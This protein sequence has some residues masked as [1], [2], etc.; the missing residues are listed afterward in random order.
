MIHPR[1]GYPPA[2]ILTLPDIVLRKQRTPN[3]PASSV[4]NSYTF[5]AAVV[6]GCSTSSPVNDFGTAKDRVLYLFWS[7]AGKRRYEMSM[8]E[9]R[10]KDGPDH[11][12]SSQTHPNK[13]DQP[14]MT[15]KLGTG[16]HHCYRWQ[17][18]PFYG[19]RHSGGDVALLSYRH[20]SEIRRMHSSSSRGWLFYCYTQLIHG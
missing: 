12:Y 19:K 20:L 6:A 8:G 16:G 9:Q 3:P 17:L 10:Q 13:L 5:S 14:A 2:F 11:S 7:S 15:I 18:C 4:R 1:N